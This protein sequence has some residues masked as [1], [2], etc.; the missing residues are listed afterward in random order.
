MIHWLI[1][2]DYPELAVGADFVIMSGFG[3]SL[4]CT[5]GTFL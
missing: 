1:R 5:S 2:V 4:L 3:D